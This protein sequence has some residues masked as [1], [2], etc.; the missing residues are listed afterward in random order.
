MTNM[1]RG[2]LLLK[3]TSDLTSFEFLALKLT[4]DQIHKS[5]YFFRPSAILFPNS[6]STWLNMCTV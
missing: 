5:T 2:N 3:G 4:L 6:L 1:T